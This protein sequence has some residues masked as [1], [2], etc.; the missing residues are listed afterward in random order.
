MVTRRVSE[1]EAVWYPGASSDRGRLSRAGGNPAWMGNG[2]SPGYAT[3]FPPAR[4]WR[5]RTR[6][7]RMRTWTYSGA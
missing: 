7:W 5:M 1:D 2:T 6:E 3:G 4:E